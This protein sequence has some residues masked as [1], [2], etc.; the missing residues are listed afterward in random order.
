MSVGR[1]ILEYVAAC[2]DP[3][4]EGQTKLLD[5]VQKLAAKIPISMSDSV[6]EN[7]AQFRKRVRV[8]RLFTAYSCER[9]WKGTEN[10]LQGPCYQSRDDHDRKISVR[11]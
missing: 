5:R 2:W 11:K 10:K 4:R 3:Y 6:W 8:C 1:P 9:A 7:L